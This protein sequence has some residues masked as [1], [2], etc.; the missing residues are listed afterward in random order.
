MSILDQMI[1]INDYNMPDNVIQVLLYFKELDEYYIHSEKC[2]KWSEF[3]F[4]KNGVNKSY[5]PS[6]W[7]KLK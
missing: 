5:Y 3:I 7:L 2:N 4:N 1:D 6:K